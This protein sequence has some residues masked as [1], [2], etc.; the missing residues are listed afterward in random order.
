MR[1]IILLFCI[2]CLNQAIVATVPQTNI[3]STEDLKF[4]QLEGD[5]SVSHKVD[6]SGRSVEFISADKTIA[7]SANLIAGIEIAEIAVPKLYINTPDSPELE[8]LV[9]KDVYL[10][11][12]I[13][14]EGN[15]YVEDFEEQAVT[16]KGRGN[17]TW[18]MPKKPMRLKFSKKQSLAGLKSSKNFVLLANFVDCTLM[19]N[20]V[21]MKIGQLLGVEYANHMVPCEVVFNGHFLGSFTLTEKIGINSS[22]VDIDET[23]GMLFELST[24]YDET[25]KF[26]SEIY[27][28]PVMVKDPDLDEIVEENPTLGTASDLFEKWR[29]DFN[30]A[31]RLAASGKSAE[32][33]DIE[34]FVN[35]LLVYDLCGN[36]EIGFPK[37]VY[38]HKEQIGSETLYKAGPML[39]FDVA[40]NK[41]R[42]IDGKLEYS[43]FND[44]LWVNSLFD[45]ITSTNEFKTLYKERL[46]TYKADLFPQ[47]LDFFDEYFALIKPSAKLNGQLWGDYDLE[48]NYAQCSFNHEEHVAQL[49]QWIINRLNYLS[50]LY[51]Q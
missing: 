4:Y 48:W 45:D 33:F 47:L 6:V 35:Y 36:S 31:E 29:V 46:A 11:A 30:E 39:D 34:S 18:S 42:L 23:T 14:L 40:F 17:S 16:I 13:R 9:E 27:D 51:G 3:Y 49:R 32:A 43:D 38:I 8:Q 5:V 44:A 2:A 12:T 22:S 50:E 19:R 10:D 21:A 1:H 24:E 7:L 15:G 20:V 26:R 28:L 25:Y 41:S 37:S